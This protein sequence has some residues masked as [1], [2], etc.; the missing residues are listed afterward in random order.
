VRTTRLATYS[1]R[2]LAAPLVLAGVAAGAAPVTAATRPAATGRAASFTVGGQ[3]K[4]VAATSARNAWAVGESGAAHP[5]ALI[6]RWNG[7]AW[8]NVPSPA[9]AG[10]GL[11]GVAALSASNAWAV[12][13]TGHT[14]LIERWDG[15][16]WTAVPSP[17]LPGSSLSGVAAVSARDAWAVGVTGTTRPRALILRWNGRSWT[18]VPSPGGY[19]SAVAATSAGNA[20]AVGTGTSVSSGKPLILR[21]NGTSWRPV[22]TPGAG[23]HYYPFLAGVAATSARRA[24]AVGDSTNCGC[25]P[26][27]SLTVR[28]DGRAWTRVPSPTLGGG[29]NLSGVAALSA[30]SAW[31]VG[32]TGSGDGPTRTLALRWNGASWAKVPSPSPGAS[33]G[34]SG[35]AATSARGAWAVGFTSNRTR[36]RFETLILHWNGTAWK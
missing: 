22:P 36:S 33:G 28:W 8:K 18:R 25:G 4:G 14:A 23:P 9:P 12:G 6:V 17:A 19:L 16:A 5:R 35:V 20:W 24:W 7:T 21:W 1:V 31:A 29:T 2:V 15:R 34:L 32:L 13:T 26:G 10:S 3:L 11:S 27:I 30:R